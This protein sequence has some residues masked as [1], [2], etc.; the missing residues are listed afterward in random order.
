LWGILSKLPDRK[1]CDE[2]RAGFELTLLSGAGYRSS[3]PFS[4]FRGTDEGKA[5]FGKAARIALRLLFPL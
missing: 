1:G 5:V 2:G 4:V 3:M